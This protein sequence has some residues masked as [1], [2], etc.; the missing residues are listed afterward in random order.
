MKVAAVCPSTAGVII[1][2]DFH[3]TR[4]LDDYCR[5]WDLVT[6]AIDSGADLVVCNEVFLTSGFFTYMNKKLQEDYGESYSLITGVMESEDAPL[7]K[8]QN[9]LIAYSNGQ[10]SINRLKEQPTDFDEMYQLVIKDCGESV[11]HTYPVLRIDGYTILPLLCCEVDTLLRGDVEVPKPAPDIITLSCMFLPGVD[12]EMLVPDPPY[13]S[14]KTREKNLVFNI[15]NSFKKFEERGFL[16]PGGKIVLSD[17]LYS[18]EYGWA[19]TTI[20][21][22]KNKISVG[23]ELLFT[24]I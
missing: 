2:W 16:K 24:E 17:P 20:V 14:P 23:E 13:C 9:R 5:K 19:P 1:D 22:E 12:A 11:H 21:A 4:F 7:P 6:K 10:L 8:W 18:R 3:R 15:E